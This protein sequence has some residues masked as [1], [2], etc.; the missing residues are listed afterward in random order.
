MTR[1][2]HREAI[3]GAWTLAVGALVLAAILYATRPDTCDCF[4]T[5]HD[6][7]ADECPAHGI[8]YN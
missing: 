3:I 6:G 8:L 5:G 4:R 7:P 1:P 2:T